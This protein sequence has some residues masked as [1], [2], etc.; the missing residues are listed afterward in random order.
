MRTLRDILL[1]RVSTLRDVDLLASI[2]GN[3]S[4]R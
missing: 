1:G 4:V 3:L 2:G